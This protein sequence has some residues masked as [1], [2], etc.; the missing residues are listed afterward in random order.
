MVSI[1]LILLTLTLIIG[2]LLICFL[3]YKYIQIRKDNFYLKNENITLQ[4]IKANY[5]NIHKEKHD[6]L[7][8][9]TRLEEKL[10]IQNESFTNQNANIETIKNSIIALNSDII[11]ENRKKILTESSLKISDITKPL[12]EA[13]EAL[14][15][16]SEEINKEDIGRIAEINTTMKIMMGRANTISQKADDLANALNT[17][18][19]MQGDFG[20]Q[21]LDNILEQFGLKDRLDYIKQGIGEN[22][23]HEGSRQQPDIMI[24][25]SQDRFLIIDSKVSLINYS[26][27]INSTSDN[28]KETYY[29]DF[30]TNI[31]KHINDLSG[32]NYNKIENA[33]PYILMFMPIEGAFY[34]A[35]QNPE[36]Y[37][38]AKK[39][40][41]ILI[42]AYNLFPALESIRHVLSIEKQNKNIKLIIDESQKMIKKVDGF[43]NDVQSV[44]KD[45]IKVQESFSHIKTTIHGKGG[46]SSIKNKISALINNSPDGQLETDTIEMDLQIKSVD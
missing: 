21:I 1:L 43:L 9:K 14:K 23:I 41:I 46:I 38:L 27:Y 10:N 12:S 32:K 44:E 24:K 20:E 25:L 34:T 42:S 45:F 26:G 5:D 22:L 35:I 39:K 11:E 29:K 4:N 31:K 33:M 7:I 2:S 37:E 19:K 6:L 15:K 36:I 13:I 8:D 17:K 3:L 16:K 28:D 30:I 18:Q 40:Q